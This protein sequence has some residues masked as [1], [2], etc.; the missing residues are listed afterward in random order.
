M[1]EGF[2]YFG[3]YYYIM[4]IQPAN[5]K[6]RSDDDAITYE[7][8]DLAKCSICSELVRCAMAYYNLKSTFKCAKCLYQLNWVEPGNNIPAG[9][10]TTCVDC[11]GQFKCMKPYLGRAPKCQWCRNSVLN[12]CEYCDTV[13]MD[14]TFGPDPNALYTDD[15]E[16][17]HWMCTNCRYT[18]N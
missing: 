6:I 3:S 15:C 12:K 9:S 2:F 10:Y 1:I 11:N 16:K 8:G 17:P 18:S 5:K 13:G 7:M 14:V 4:A